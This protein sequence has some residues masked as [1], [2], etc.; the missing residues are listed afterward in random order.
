MQALQCWW[1]LETHQRLGKARNRFPLTVLRS[2][3]ATLP[4][5]RL[6]TSSLYKC[7]DSKFLLL[8]HAVFGAFLQ[9]PGILAEGDVWRNSKYC[10]SPDEPA[11]RRSSDTCS[12]LTWSHIPSC[13]NSAWIYTPVYPGYPH[14][15]WSSCC[16]LPSLP[17][18]AALDHAD[19]SGSA[20]DSYKAAKPC[21]VRVPPDP[22]SHDCP[23]PN[24]SLLYAFMKLITTTYI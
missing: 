6:G 22:D 14:S 8:S 4:T 9:H 2:F 16:F 20:A 15:P 5:L 13:R 12:P 3:K 18:P 23:P 10:F 24:F 17:F 11:A 19:T 21:S 7:Q 1:L